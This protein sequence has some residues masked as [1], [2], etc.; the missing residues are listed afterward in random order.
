MTAGANEISL[1]TA[2]ETVLC[3]G[4]GTSLIAS[5][6][7]S[8]AGKITT[9]SSGGMNSRAYNIDEYNAT[10]N[11]PYTGVLLQ[12]G[13]I[14]SLRI[15]NNKAGGT[16]PVD[17]QLYISTMKADKT[18]VDSLI[19]TPTN[20]V[21]TGGITS[22]GT[23]SGL[24]IYNSQTGT[25]DYYFNTY[26]NDGSIDLFIRNDAI[27][28]SPTATNFN[29]YTFTAGK[30]QVNSLSI[31]P[32]GA[33]L[34]GGLLS[35][36]TNSGLQ[37]NN[38]ATG[39]ANYNLQAYTNGG[40]C[41]LLIK[42]D[43]FSGTPVATQFNFYTFNTSKAQSTSMTI[44]NSAI[45][46][47]LPITLQSTFA[48]APA[49]GQLGFKNSGNNIVNP[50]TSTIV[51]NANTIAVPVGVWLI[52]NSMNIIVN[53]TGGT[54][55]LVDTCVSS[56]TTL[57]T[58]LVDQASRTTDAISTVYPA[59]TNHN[60]STSFVY[61]NATSASVNLYQLYTQTFSSGS[62]GYFAYYTLTRIG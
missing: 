16:T 25:A 10:A 59:N 18:Q 21:F 54:T 7:I 36:G 1:G 57:L 49:S 8:A 58:S 11:T 47:N 38:I 41:E 5:G 2:T 45:Q 37:L 17:T 51:Y 32:T 43:S 34:T 60:F 52:T 9:T 50:I 23:S 13:S 44:G 15:F 62:Y 6:A 29:F 61:Q 27:L 33:V 24:Q 19:L 12:D 40:A 31:T 22:K 20:A 46:M 26:V 55:T 42:N 35:T 3:K 53:E 39:T 48:S 56:S 4:T 14:G 30:A 28:A